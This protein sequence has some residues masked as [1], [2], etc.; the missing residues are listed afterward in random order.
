MVPNLVLFSASQSPTP[1]TIDT[2]RTTRRYSGYR[3]VTI[4][5]FALIAVMMG[6]DTAPSNQGGIENW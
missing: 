1:M 2:A 3:N 5:P 4:C 6:V